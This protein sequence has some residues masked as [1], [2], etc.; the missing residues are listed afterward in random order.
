VNPAIVN[1]QFVQVALPIVLT[2]FIAAWMNGRAIDAIN[3]RIDDVNRRLDEIVGRLTSIEKKLDDSRGR[4]G[5]HV[6]YREVEM[7]SAVLNPTQP[8]PTVCWRRS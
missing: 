1:S 6:V 3:K 5:A 2:I 4:G 8:N 7:T